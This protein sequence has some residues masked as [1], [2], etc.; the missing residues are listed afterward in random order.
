[1]VGADFGDLRAQ[2]PEPDPIFAPPDSGIR[3][4]ASR[5]GPPLINVDDQFCID[6]YEVTNKQYAEFLAHASEVSIPNECAWKLAAGLV[7][8]FWSTPKAE[9]KNYPVTY[10]DFCDA[11]TYCQWAGKRLCGLTSGERGTLDDVVQ[12]EAYYACSSAGLNAYPYGSEYV[13]NNCA[14]NRARFS[15]PVMSMSDCRTPS[16]VFDLS[17][18]VGEWQN[19]CA[20][21]EGGSMC[22]NGSFPGDIVDPGGAMFSCAAENSDA[23]ST[24]APD[25][26]FRCCASL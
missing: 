21:V 10:V 8:G 4:C 24:R 16:G 9:D 19:L 14:V 6:Q 7:P 2:E 18:N 15:A 17:G 11:L 25:I 5:A 12:G 20:D 26:G 23:R 22:S 13:E 3:F 1:V